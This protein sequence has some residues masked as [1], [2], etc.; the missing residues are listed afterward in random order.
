MRM[1]NPLCRGLFTGFLGVVFSFSPTHLAAEDLALLTRRVQ[2]GY[3]T[4]AVTAIGKADESSSS[5]PA[6][7][8]PLVETTVASSAA[9]RQ[10]LIGTIV[11]ARWLTD[12]NE[13][14]LVVESARG[15]W[16]LFG[17]PRGDADL[18]PVTNAQMSI[19]REHLL[20]RKEIAASFQLQMRAQTETL[21]RLRADADLIGDLGKVAIVREEAEHAR[22]RLVGLDRDIVNLKS[23]IQRV[24]VMAAPENLSRREVELTQQIADL[25]QAARQ[26]E[27]GESARRAQG[28]G[29]LR[30]SM[31]LIEQTRFDDPAALQSELVRL[32]RRR[33]ELEESV[34]A[35]SQSPVDYE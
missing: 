6:L 21:R 27:S 33:Q 29:A 9:E 5:F 2:L 10:W 28:E 13:V 8:V 11:P 35:Q 3:D 19:L 18:V 4:L 7:A 20:K 26:A 30:T 12:Q 34:A 15:E 14:L 25:A 31:E 23:A 17:I 22:E 32:R 24:R 16:T 1:N